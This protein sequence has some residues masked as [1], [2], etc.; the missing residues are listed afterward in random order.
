MKKTQITYLY[1]TIRRN[2]VSFLAVAM[3][4]ATGI[5][6][7]LGDQSAAQA[8]LDDANNYFIENQLQ[9]LEISAP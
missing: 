4:A 7:Y 1:R 9:T 6:I 8:I 5:S 3:M 2:L